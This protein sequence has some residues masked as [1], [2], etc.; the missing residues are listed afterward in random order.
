MSDVKLYPRKKKELEIQRNERRRIGVYMVNSKEEGRSVKLTQGEYVR[1][2]E[3]SIMGE[4]C[5]GVGIERGED[6]GE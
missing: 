4:K 2:E 3:G 5:L 1:S 6:K